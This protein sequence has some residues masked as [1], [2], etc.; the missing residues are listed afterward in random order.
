MP[1][2][3]NE[4]RPRILVVEDD[5]SLN[6]FLAKVVQRSGCTPTP[7]LTGEEAL[8]ILRDHR[9]HIDWLLTDIKSPGAIDGWLLGVR[10]V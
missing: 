1:S 9:A 8:A 4:S 7:A 3:D 6:A 5:Q 10:S 2:L